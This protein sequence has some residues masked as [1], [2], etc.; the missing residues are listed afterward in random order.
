MFESSMISEAMKLFHSFH[1]FAFV[2]A[3]RNVYN[4]LKSKCTC[5]SYYGTN[6]VFFTYI[7]KEKISFWLLF[8][9]LY[10]ISKLK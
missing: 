9:H 5:T 10:K 3:V 4:F 2:R 1:F 8:L 7:V 6:I